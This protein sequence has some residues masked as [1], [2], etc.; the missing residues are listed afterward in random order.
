M[1]LHEL[2]FNFEIHKIKTLKFCNIRILLPIYKESIVIIV[3]VTKILQFIIIVQNMYK[4]STYNIHKRIFIRI[5]HFLYLS[6][7]SS[8]V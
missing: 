3:M 5:L 6:R 8:K 7:F 2:K 1:N 4:E